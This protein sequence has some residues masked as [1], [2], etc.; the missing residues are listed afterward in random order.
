MPL[1]SNLYDST[2][3]IIESTH[4]PSL[5]CKLRVTLYEDKNEWLIE[6]E[7]VSHFDETYSVYWEEYC[8]IPTHESLE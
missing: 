2:S 1:E 4:T 8:V 7:R 5:F 3:V 6:R